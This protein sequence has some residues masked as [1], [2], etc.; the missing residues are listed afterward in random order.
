MQPILA[1][2]GWLDNSGS[3]KRLASHIV[4]D[5]TSLFALD[6]PGTGRSSHLPFFYNYHFSS[7]ASILRRVQKHFNFEDLILFAH[8]GGSATAFLFCALYPELVKGYFAVDYIFYS[9]KR[10]GTRAD[11]TGNI[12]D[13]YLNI[14]VKNAQPKLYT[15]EEAKNI[16]I[17]GSLL[18]ATNPELVEDLMERGLEKVGDKFIFSRDIRLKHLK[19]VAIDC[20]SVDQAEA[21]AKEIKCNICFIKAKDSP[22][23]DLGMRNFPTI[24]D[25]LKE[26]SKSFQYHEIEGNHHIH[27]EH[28]EQIA[29]IA[30]LFLN[31]I[32]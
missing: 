28:S 18:G 2:H 14:A 11:N 29:G 16:W 27:M 9:Y 5:N 24:I 1:I 8:S 19:A 15:W 10:E 13:E 17:K 26:S 23:A 32:T 31:S 4:N 22:F 12:L 3:W 6:L 7:S 25:V 20:F 21:L 30:R